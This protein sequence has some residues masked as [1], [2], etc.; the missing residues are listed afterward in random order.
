VI[1]AESRLCDIGLWAGAWCSGNNAYYLWAN[2]S[3][4]D[5]LTKWSQLQGQNLRLVD[6]EV[7]A[8]AGAAGGSTGGATAA[9]IN[10]AGKPTD[11]EHVVRL[12]PRRSF[13]RRSPTR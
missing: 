13:S 7:T 4:G 5:F 6:L 11:E 1:F 8:L 9:T 10:P 12:A 2:V 3:E